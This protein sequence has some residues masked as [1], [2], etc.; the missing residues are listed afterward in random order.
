M[1]IGFPGFFCFF[2]RWMERKEKRKEALGRSF[3][4]LSHSYLPNISFLSHSYLRKISFLP[5]DNYIMKVNI[6]DGVKSI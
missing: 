6:E 4:F 1:R 5:Y 2:E 3:S